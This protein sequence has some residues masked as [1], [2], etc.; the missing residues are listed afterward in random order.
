MRTMLIRTHMNDL[1][2]VTCDVHYEN[3]R[4]HKVNADNRVE[5]PI[6]LFPMSTPDPET[7]KLI[8]MKDQELRRM[9]Q[10][11]QKMQQQMHEQDL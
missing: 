9:Q 3:Y 7:E 10:M 1:K 2:E 4:A 6:P 8:Q 5:S 11:L